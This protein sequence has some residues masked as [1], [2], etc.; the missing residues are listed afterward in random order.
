MSVGGLAGEQH[1]GG[2]KVAHS[3]QRQQQ[4]V[5]PKQAPLER[6]AKGR[7]FRR[8]EP[9]EPREQAEV[10]HADDVEVFADDL[11]VALV[12]LP[13]VG[14]DVLFHRREI[15]Q[16]L[17]CRRIGHRLDDDQRTAGLD[18]LAQRFETGPKIHMVKD[19]IDQGDVK[20]VSGS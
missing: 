20:G 15:A 18:A 5:D 13:F 3:R 11:D 4:A 10:T 17:Q 16:L 12:E 14:A 8:Q 9:V 1:H 2:G 7:G 19:E 6:V